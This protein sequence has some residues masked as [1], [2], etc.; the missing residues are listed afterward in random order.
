MWRSPTADVGNVASAD[1]AVR[2][3]GRPEPM[4]TGAGVLGDRTLRDTTGEH[5][6]EAVEKV[7]EKV[8]AEAVEPGRPVPDGLAGGLGC[9][10]AAAPVVV[11]PACR[12]RVRCHRPVHR[13]ARRAPLAV[14]AP[15]RG[16]HRRAYRRWGARRRRGDVRIDAG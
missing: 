8:A 5:V 1:R 13:R 14:V 10:P 7:V 9:F 11:C 2:E 3:F 16:G 15:H 12:S 4:C 6:R